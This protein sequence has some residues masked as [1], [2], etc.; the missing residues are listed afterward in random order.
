[1]SKPNELVYDPTKS[2][3]ENITDL[4]AVAKELGDRLISLNQEV[5][6]TGDETYWFPG[7]V[8]PVHVGLY[9]KLW[10]IN[11]KKVLFWAWWDNGW[12]VSDTSK[13]IA[14]SRKNG[15]KSVGGSKFA[16]RGCKTHGGPK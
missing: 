5:P 9:Q 16:W 8:S 3:E 14:V 2:M 7:T 15:F 12:R 13:D 10:E 11:G 1:M 4:K 6:A